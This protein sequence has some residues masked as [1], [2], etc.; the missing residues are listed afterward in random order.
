MSDDPTRPGGP[1]DGTNDAA[2]LSYIDDDPDAGADPPE[3]ELDDDGNPIEPEPDGG[4]PPEPEPVE[5]R[6]PAA[7]QPRRGE[8]HRWRERYEGLAREVAEL[9]GRMSAPAPQQP[10]ASPAE[11]QRQEAEKWQRRAEMSPVE[12]VQD[13]QREAEQ[14]FS[15][16]LI[17]QQVQTQDLL[18]R[19]DYERRAATNR[20][21]AQYRDR[22]ES[23]VAQ[24]R[25][26][27][28]IVGRRQALAWLWFE[29][30]EKKQS[31]GDAPRQRARAAGRVAAATTRPTGARS[32][33]ARG[34]GRAA[35]GSS[36][37]DDRLVDEYFRN[38]GRL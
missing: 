25:A 11:L 29:D 34:N 8:A 13:V 5:G 16:A 22:V 38:G 30:Q 6:Q 2:D 20:A 4:E 10:M 12:L 18:D 28:Q 32:D 24:E 19:Q 33:A 36:A 21:Y 23:L 14:R 15:Q 1:D 26:R 27:G 9:R 35:P 17:A 7:R 31:G 3:P 37:E